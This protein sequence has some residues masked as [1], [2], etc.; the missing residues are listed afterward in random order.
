LLPIYSARLQ[1]ALSAAGIGGIQ[2]L[3]VRVLRPNGDEISGFAIANILN[4]VA[5]LDN[6][7]SKYLVYDDNWPDRKGEIRA[8]I[9]PVLR[10]K[11]VEQF[12]VIRLKEYAWSIYVSDR[13]RSTFELNKLTGYGFRSLRPLARG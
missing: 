9:R 2:Y 4:F 1:E 10:A 3:P 7:Q 8:I 11:A 12:D 13:F 5:A 6:S